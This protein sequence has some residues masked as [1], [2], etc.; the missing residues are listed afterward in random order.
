[1][2]ACE[3]DGIASELKP[4]VT[5]QDLRGNVVEV[6]CTTNVLIFSF[7]HKGTGVI[8]DTEKGI[9]LT[10]HHVVADENE[11]ERIEVQLPGV[12]DRVPATTIRHCASIDRARMQIP[13]R[14]YCG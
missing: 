14:Y 6:F 2:F 11:C 10:V 3:F 4:T 7:T 12:A 9:V 8:I 1:M 13:R 5:A